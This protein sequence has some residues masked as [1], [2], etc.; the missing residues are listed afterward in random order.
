MA[1]I[2]CQFLAYNTTVFPTEFYGTYRQGAVAIEFVLGLLLLRGH[3]LAS[4]ES[5]FRRRAS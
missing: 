4:F 2:Y 3:K 5:W 1:F